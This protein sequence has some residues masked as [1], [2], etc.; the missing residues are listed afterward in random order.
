M[1]VDAICDKQRSPYNKDCWNSTIS[2]CCVIC[3]LWVIRNPSHIDRDQRVFIPSEELFRLVCVD[4]KNFNI[5]IIALVSPAKRHS[6]TLKESSF[7][8]PPIC[9]PSP[10][11]AIAVNAI[12]S[13]FEMIEHNLYLQFNG[14]VTF[15][16][17]QI[18]LMHNPT[19]KGNTRKTV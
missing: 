13:N 16:I 17:G 2:Y 3:S 7:L 11:T 19:F 10:K 4:I 6:N 8:N 9:F 5:I 15:R 18:N 12:C 14:T 1:W